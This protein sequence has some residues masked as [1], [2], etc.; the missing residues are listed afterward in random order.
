[1]TATDHRTAAEREAYLRELED[2]RYW[3]HEAASLTYEPGA[4]IAHVIA[5]D[6]E[7]NG[8]VIARDPDTDPDPRDGLIYIDLTTLRWEPATGSPAADPDV[9]A[10]V[11]C[12]HCERRVRFHEAYWERDDEH[13]DFPICLDCWVESAHDHP[14]D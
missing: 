5:S 7:Q 9:E 13:G 4:T 11:T 10:D 12:N 3:E 6:P 1:M 8:P 2:R 14:Y